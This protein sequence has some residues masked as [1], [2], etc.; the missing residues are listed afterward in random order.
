[1]ILSS[2]APP[3]LRPLARRLAIAI[4]AGLTLILA[5]CASLPFEEPPPAPVTPGFRGIGQISP[6]SKGNSVRAV[7][8]DGSV[9][10]GATD[11][12]SGTQAF[13][14]TADRFQLFGRLPNPDATEMEKLEHGG[15]HA[16]LAYSVSGDGRTVVGGGSSEDTSQA[17]TWRD[18]QLRMLATPPETTSS[19]A[20]SISQDGKTVVGYAITPAGRQ[21]IRWYKGVVNPLEDLPGGLFRSF[22]NG[23][24]GSGATVVG[25][26]YSGN[27]DHAVIWSKDVPKGIAPGYA[28]AVTA[29]G[30][31]VVGGTRTKQ[32]R[33]EAF[34]W[35]D[36]QLETLGLLP[37]ETDPRSR[38][39]GASNDGK[40]VVGWTNSPEGAFIW[41]EGKGLRQLREVL[42]EDYGL[43]LEGWELRWATGIT[44]D[45]Q[46]IVGDGRNPDGKPEGWIATI[47][48]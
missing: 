24:S 10:V 16:T 31:T 35:Q 47:P 33:L 38:A 1:L 18:N 36:E 14:W 42:V 12:A 7:S 9:L 44:P 15:T 45:G 11:A 28:S 43:D 25:G 27:G 46:T 6:E 8:A 17:W 32:S 5:G 37:R 30:K 39:T 2:S 41:E 40:R 26:G 3:H 22:A 4:V 13:R 48:R 29:N 34:R 20:F 19:G 21:G 23:V